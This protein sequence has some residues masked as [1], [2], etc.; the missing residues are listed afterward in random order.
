MSPL[1]VLCV[2]VCCMA[3]FVGVL[4]FL[5]SQGVPLPLA[6]LGLYLSAVASMLGM[7]RR[8]RES[9]EGFE[10]GRWYPLDSPALD[11]GAEPE[12]RAFGYSVPGQ[13]GPLR[14]GTHRA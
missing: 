6:L 14:T 4:A 7:Q 8:A 9:C 5:T 13:R 11:G 12:E 3:M 2:I 10:R 1:Q